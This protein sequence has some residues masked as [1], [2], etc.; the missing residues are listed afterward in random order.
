MTVAGIQI[1]QLGIDGIE[2]VTVVI[3][4]TN[5]SDVAV[6]KGDAA[7]NSSSTYTSVALARDSCV[8][9]GNVTA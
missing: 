3:S 1:S 2:K 7:D 8:A 6:R 4:S 5:T 9:E